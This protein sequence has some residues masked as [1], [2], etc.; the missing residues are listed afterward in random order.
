MDRVLTRT[1]PVSTCAYAAPWRFSSRAA[2]A[3]AVSDV[4]QRFGWS[5]RTLERH[6]GE[7]VGLSPKAFARIRRFRHTLT[8][9]AVN[10]RTAWARTA[11]E[12]GYADQAHLSREVSALTGRAPGALGRYLATIDHVDVTLRPRRV[13]FVQD[14]G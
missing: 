13:A 6:F 7:A 1:A 4:A 3:G 5:L 10:R 8:D 14:T 11:A 12:V 2:R 9:I